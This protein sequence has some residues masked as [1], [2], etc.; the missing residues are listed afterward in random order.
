ML[1]SFDASCE[2][3]LRHEGAL[4]VVAVNANGLELVPF[5]ERVASKL[6]HIHDRVSP[7]QGNHYS[8]PG[9]VLIGTLQ[10]AIRRL[11]YDAR[12]ESLSSAL[13]DLALQI[14]SVAP[15]SWHSL[16]FPDA[17]VKI[18]PR[19]PRSPRQQPVDH[20]AV[21]NALKVLP[22]LLRQL[23]RRTLEVRFSFH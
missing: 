4:R 9:L 18:S 15:I 2:L 20:N 3:L 5:E 23:L 16:L 1:L 13:R 19:S 21:V 17:A 7:L 14:A 8:M 22:P 12:S 6:P 10:Y 11:R